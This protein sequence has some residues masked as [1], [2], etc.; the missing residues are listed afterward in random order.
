MKYLGDDWDEHVKQKLSNDGPN[1]DDTQSCREWET[2]D[3]VFPEASSE[4]RVAQKL[5]DGVKDSETQ[6]FLSE[7]FGIKASSNVQQSDWA[8]FEE[9]DDEEENDEDFVVGEKEK[10]SSDGDSSVDD[11]DEERNLLKERIDADELDALSVESLGKASFSNVSD[12]DSSENKKTRRSKRKRSQLTS[13]KESDFASDDES[14]SAERD[15]GK[16]DTA[17]IIHGKRNRT[18]VDYRK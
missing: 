1:G 15:G 4:L 18:K 3:D 9:D 10:F 12:D 17:N 2:A 11:M 16:L 7:T 6:E 8:L 14:T 5:K 13:E